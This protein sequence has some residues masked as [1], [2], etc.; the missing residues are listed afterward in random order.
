VTAVWV[1]AR[2]ELRHLRRSIVS[3]AVLVAVGAT[4]VMA[5]TAGARRTDS[6]YP[7]FNRD[8]RAADF[9]LLVPSIED[10]PGVDPDRIARLPQVSVFEPVKFAFL[11]FRGEFLVALARSS[12]PVAAAVDRVKI[13]EGRA[14]DPNDPG[15]V[16]VSLRGREL[17]LRVGQSF[18]ARSFPD[19]FP[20]LAAAL[21]KARLTFRVVGVAAAPG[22]FPPQVSEINP[23]MYLTPAFFS[24]FP[25]VFEGTP[26]SALIRLKHGAADLPA[27]EAGIDRTFPQERTIPFASLERRNQDA[28]VQRS[29]HLQAVALWL[30]AS[31]AALA[32]VLIFSQTAARQISLDSDDNGA[33]SALGMTR[34]QLWALGVIRTG[35]AGVAGVLLAV[36]VAYLLSG[37]APIGLARTAEPSPGRL[38]DWTVLGL[39]IPVTVLIVVAIAALPAWRAARGGHRSTGEL[40]ATRSRLA[41]LLARA[42]AGPAAVAG[43]RLALERG[44]GRTAVPV[45]T[46]IGGVTLGLAVLAAAAT[47][48]ASLD[49]LVHVPRLYGVPWDMVVQSDGSQTNFSL[50]GARLLTLPEVR[51]VSVGGQATLT[52]GGRD[53]ETIVLDQVGGAAVAPAVLEGRSPRMGPT[54]GPV[55][56]A[57][58]TRTLHELGLRL[59]Q[60]IRGRIQEINRNVAFKIVGRAVLPSFNESTRLGEGAWLS[61]RA[62]AA[63]AGLDPSTTEGGANHV[64][65]D[66]RTGVAHGL[67]LQRMAD[68]L[69]TKVD[70]DLF[71]PP[72]AAASDV[73][74]FGR[75][76]NMP[77]I[78]GAVLALFA[79]ATLI[80]TLV[81]AVRRRRRDLA[82]LKTI[83]FVRS[84]IRRT[85]GVQ[86]LTLTL[87]ALAIGVPAGI[88]IGRWLWSLLATELGVVNEPVIP[89]TSALLTVP[90]A[91]GLAALIAALPARSAART[92]PALVLRSE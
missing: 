20:S 83:G 9:Y 30:L 66:L 91:V 89:L 54:G 60:V 67:F 73:V 82:I 26:D 68:F 29:F 53:V 51:G 34:G 77:Q 39:G 81:T 42:G 28:N 31:L 25:N 52:L 72:V 23:L 11:G 14:A 47:F 50:A 2:N 41:G 75:V 46:S 17:G 37:F 44:R 65:L 85:V 76:R 8:F 22:G 90:V 21:E 49:R 88:A 19:V 92:Q 59:G 56:M 24:R 32:F 69:G 45:R 62:V 87:L 33:L 74:N 35:V 38:A 16:V 6:A 64:F 58:G 36:P 3:M 71:E 79:G 4:V 61:Y 43:T 27:F 5:S 10:I 70:E 57:V 18:P 48:G 63:A 80:H 86:A 13:V 40:F 78:L 15:E 1:R 7:R 12:N 55:E 84:Q